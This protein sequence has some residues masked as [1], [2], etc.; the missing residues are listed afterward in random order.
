MSITPSNEHMIATK[1]CSNCCQ[2][3][4]RNCSC[5]HAKAIEKKQKMYCYLTF[6][7]TVV[8][9]NTLFNMIVFKELPA[10]LKMF[11]RCKEM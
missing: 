5:G 1:D 11:T 9:Y 3:D 4:F 8:T 2:K 10:I 6:C 7:L